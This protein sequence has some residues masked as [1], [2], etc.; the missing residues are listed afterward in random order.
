[1]FPVRDLRVIQ[2]VVNEKIVKPGASLTA[3][4]L[5]R[6]V[7]SKLKTRVAEASFGPILA[8]EIAADNIVGIEGKRKVGYCRV[9]KRGRPKKP[10]W[11]RSTAAAAAVDAAATPKKRGRPPKA[12]PV[13][14]PEIAAEEPVEACAEVCAEVGE[15]GGWTRFET[16]E[17]AEGTVENVA[18]KYL[19]HAGETEDGLC[20]T[21]VSKEHWAAEHC[22]ASESPEEVAGLLESLGFC[23]VMEST[24]EDSM[25]RE[26]DEVKKTLSDAGFQTDDAFSAFLEG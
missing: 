21:I 10:S 23:E 11:M 19:F 1:M 12:P 3:K 5:Y 16:V 17:A 9:V 6:L 14:T 15:P 24:Y 2:N 8:A 20:V 25:D 18:E 4:E 22:V 26:L 7:S 13:E